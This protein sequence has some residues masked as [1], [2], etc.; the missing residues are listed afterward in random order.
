MLLMASIAVAFLGGCSDNS[1]VSSRIADLESKVN[2]LERENEELEREVFELKLQNEELE[3]QIP[4][5]DDDC[6]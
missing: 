4:G 2:E 6:S 1:D 5:T 3:S